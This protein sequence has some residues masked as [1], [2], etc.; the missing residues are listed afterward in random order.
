MP[1]G[2]WVVMII[3]V[4]LSYGPLLAPS[5][6]A[7]PQIARPSSIVVAPVRANA[8]GTVHLTSDTA[9]GDLKKP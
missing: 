3:V 8:A 2:S 7:K 6:P 9:S 1:R 5:S 4:V